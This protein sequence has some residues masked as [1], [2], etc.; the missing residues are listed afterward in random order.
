MLKNI[1][2]T[3]ILLFSFHLTLNAFENQGFEN[4]TEKQSWIDFICKNQCFLILWQVSKNNLI[5]I[6]WSFSWTGIIGYGF[7]NGNE[8]IP[9]EINENIFNKLT[10]SLLK[11]PYF[12]QLPQ[13]VNWII[14]IEWELT[15]KNLLIT[16]RN[17]SIWER[18]K[19][20][21]QDFSSIEPLTP[22]TINLR[23]WVK[24]GNTS[25]VWIA[26]IM[27]FLVFLY[28]FFTKKINI[29][30]IMILWI[31]LFLFISFR[32]LFTN[33]S[34]TKAWLESYSFQS[35][36][37]KT[38][39]DSWDYY[40]FI[41]QVRNS[42]NLDSQKWKKCHIYFESFRDWP[43]VGRFESVYAKPCYLTNEKEKADYFIFYKKE[44]PQDF[45]GKILLEYNSSYL[46]KK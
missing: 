25:I 45:D 4:F 24:I 40:S 9:W 16:T 11:Y 23:Y 8:I 35:I 43:F 37:N 26:Y 15:W 22:Y 12:S 46:L 41:Q 33:Y 1:I 32:N 39:S 10:L 29:N 6:T 14:F 38:F 7:L 27:F 34:I 19:S 42:I 31:I 36:E 18:I 13:D 5:E 17:Q 28:L 3:L 44:I 2:L 21:W 20:L 30:S